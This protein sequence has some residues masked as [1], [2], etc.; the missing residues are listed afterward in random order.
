MQGGPFRFSGDVGD[1]VAVVELDVSQILREPALVAD[2][3]G[4][5]V[6][7]LVGERI[8]ASPAGVGRRVRPLGVR[9]TGAVDGEEDEQVANCHAAVIVEVGGDGD[10]A[11]F[12]DGVPHRALAA[13]GAQGN[14]TLTHCWSVLSHAVPSPQ[15]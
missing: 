10:D 14:A 7:A 4:G 11:L 8:A 3:N 9:R 1:G 13:G 12:I 2:L 5:V 15:N 6:V